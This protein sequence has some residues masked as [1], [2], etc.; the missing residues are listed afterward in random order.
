M[1]SLIGDNAMISIL[2]CHQLDDSAT[3]PPSLP[4]ISAQRV[5]KVNHLKSWKIDQQ[6][7]EVLMKWPLRYFCDKSIVIG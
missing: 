7:L 5:N 6:M 1:L 2:P 4:T 3:S